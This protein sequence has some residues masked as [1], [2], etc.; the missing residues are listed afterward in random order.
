MKKK[1]KRKSLSGSLKNLLLALMIPMCLLLV[2]VLSMFT[3][4]NI[5]YAAASGNI[6]R[7][8]QFN[9]N[10]KDDIDLKM[11]YFATDSE[12]ATGIPY[13]EVETALTLA[14]SLEDSTHNRE[15]L[16][17][18]SSVINLCVTLREQIEQI[19]LTEGYDER[20]EQLESNVY[21]LTELIQNYMYTYL[22]YEAGELA[23]IQESMSRSIYLAIIVAAAATLLTVI[24]TV[25]KTVSISRSITRPIDSLYTR[26]QSIGEGNLEPMPPVYAEDVK[27]QAL[28]SG[29]EEMVGRL[30]QLMQLNREEA[31]RIRSMELMLL[32][33]Q[34]N[35]HFL[36][37]TLDTIIW[38]VETG[39]N[40]Q[41]V[42]MVSSLSNFFRTSLSKGQDVIT[43][44][45]EE[46]HVRSYL[47]IQ[48]VRY[49]DILQYDISIDS[50]LG[51]TRLP[52]LTL[53]PIV[54]NAL[55]HGIKL[56]RG[57][58]SIFITGEQEGKN[59][60]LRIVDTGIGMDEETLE[61]V[62]E[63]IRSEHSKGFGMAAVYKRLK[64]MFR[65][66]CDFT[67]SSSQGEGT[68]VTITIPLEYRA[69]GGET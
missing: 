44:A 15:S 40:D 52:K 39:R 38:L 41:A 10:F 42:D 30:G 58:G 64:L 21:I 18:V 36:Y 69:D 68:A 14:K 34:I 43:L 19:R 54:E 11:Y 29:F 47:E 12:Y 5:R 59:V 62:R 67:I 16:K 45:E 51:Y 28:S 55:Y 6:A 49:R 24:V 35:P 60:V 33:S 50:S 66:N 53:Q 3:A 2:A 4:Y 27:V 57:V 56:K 37:N 26:V 13:S 23:A 46:L 48:Q 61:H 17:A 63:D 8:S 32:Q 20:I 25:R 7:A 31:E 9:R 22:F 1:D 65:E